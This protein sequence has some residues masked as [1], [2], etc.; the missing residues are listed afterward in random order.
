MAEGAKRPVVENWV[1]REKY[2]DAQGRM[3]GKRRTIEGCGSLGKKN[4]SVD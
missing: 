1:K 3:W 4:F 2:H